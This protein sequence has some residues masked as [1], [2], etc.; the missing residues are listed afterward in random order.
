M[1]EIQLREYVTLGRKLARLTA[2]YQE[3]GRKMGAPGAPDISGMPRGNGN[4]GTAL[5]NALDIRSTI[6]ENIEEVS[7]LR[8]AA[9][10]KLMKVLDLVADEAQRAVFVVLYCDG[11]SIREAANRLNYSAPYVYQL[12]R[13]ILE[14]ASAV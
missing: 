14:I 9:Y 8:K 7:A 11:L 12:R 3:E 10:R 4:E 6:L 13:G 1:T 5:Y 2:M